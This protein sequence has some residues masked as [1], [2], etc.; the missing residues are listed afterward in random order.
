MTG[1]VRACAVTARS[2][3]RSPTNGNSVGNPTLPTLPAPDAATW[4][5]LV[6]RIGRPSGSNRETTFRR[7]HCDN[8]QSRGEKMGE[9]GVG[10][11]VPREEDP[12]LLR[13]AGRY[14]DDM[15]QVG[16]L[17]AFVLRSPHAHARIRSIDVSAA[18]AMPGVVLAL[19]GDD[20]AVTGLGTQ[21][22]N[23]PRKRR[24]GSPAFASPPL[25]LAAGAPLDAMTPCPGPRLPPSRPRSTTRC[26]PPWRRWRTRSSR[27]RAPS[28][29]NA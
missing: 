28:M 7:R 16:L 6:C 17:R 12:Y 10:R 21:K 15:A 29:T 9:Y 25:G 18:K 4:G 2:T 20:P 5:L 8:A 19:A 27:A 26:C 1:R 22:P 13:G 23:T 14:V 11:A 24:D 3:A